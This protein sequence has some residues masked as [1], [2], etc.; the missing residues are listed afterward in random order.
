MA[1]Q[2]LQVQEDHK[3]IL[4]HKVPKDLEVVP[5]VQEPQE[6]KDSKEH[7]V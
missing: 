1:R 3:E 2:E 6:D 4:V 5:V 7:K